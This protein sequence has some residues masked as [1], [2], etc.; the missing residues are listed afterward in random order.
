[1]WII[2]L[3]H[4][5]SMGD[6]FSASIN[7]TSRLL[8][9]A[10][11]D[12]KLA[13][14]KEV[15]IEEI[16]ELGADVKLALFGFTSMTHLVFEG[17]A[18]QKAA[19]ESSLEAL[20]ATN[21][22]SID[23][24]LNA[25]AD[26]RASHRID[27]LARV[28]LIS[29]GLSDRNAAKS[30]ARR[31]LELSMSIHFILIDPTEEG[32]AFARDV[33][34]SLGG[35][36]FSVTSRAQLK[37]STED[38][39]NA[40][41]EDL[42]I[43]ESFNKLAIDQSEA[44]RAEA[45]TRDP[46]EFTTGYPSRIRSNHTYPLLVWVYREELKEKVEQRLGKLAKMLGE[47]PKSSQMESNTLIPIGTRLEITPRIAGVSVNPSR[48]QLTWF[49]EIE[50]AV[51]RIQYDESQG[52]TDFCVGFIDVSASGLLIAKIP[53][54]ISFSQTKAQLLWERSNAQMISRVF[55]SYAR[56]DLAV[57]G[58]KAAYK[59]LGI[60]LFIDKY[61]ISSG[62]P[63]QDVIRRSIGDHDLFQLFW[64]QYAADSDNVSKEWHLALSIAAQRS[65]DFVRPLYWSEPMA[66]PPKD[67]A[68]I[69]FTFL[70]LRNLNID[71]K[72]TENIET[73]LLNEV[74]ADFPI[75]NVVGYGNQA[76]T[77]L[78]HDMCKIVPFLEQIVQGRYYP[79]VSF[80]VDEHIVR[81]T[82]Q[83]W[84]SLYHNEQDGIQDN[85]MIDHVLDLLQSLA[86]AFHVG[87]LV[88]KD[89]YE[90]EKRE[91]FFDVL[92]DCAKEEYW[93]VVRMSEGVFFGPVRQY[94]GGHDVL[95]DSVQS[96]QSLLEAVIKGDQNGF[97]IKS[98]LQWLLE[99]ASDKDSYI[100][101]ETVT[102]NLLEDLSSF[103]TARIKKAAC[104]LSNSAIPQLAAKYQ[105][106]L[107]FGCPDHTELRLCR[108]FPEYISKLCAQW[109]CYVDTALMKRGDITIE[110]GFSVPNAALEWM[111]KNLL[112]IQIRREEEASGYMI[113]RGPEVYFDL[114]LSDYR[115]CVQKLSEV[116]LKILNQ[117]GNYVGLDIIPVAA[118]TYG[119]Y[120]PASAE[121]AQSKFEG[122]LI[123]YGWPKQA[124][125]PGQGKI[126][127]CAEATEKIKELL[128]NSG[129]VDARATDLAHRIALAVL[130]HEQFHSA[131]ATAIGPDG[132]PP[133]GTQQWDS[134][135]EGRALNEALATWAERHFFRKDPEMSEYIGAYINSGVYPAWPYSGAN[136]IEEI[137]QNG[138]LPAVRGW[139]QYLRDDPMNAQR[140]FDNKVKRHITV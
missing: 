37:K 134:W 124:G 132:R 63:W 120:I 56:E 19:I 94:F 110:I 8:M 3:D 64:S 90:H 91:V 104:N 46:V 84:S 79:P 97:Y 114:G 76:V 51:F 60:N 9:E 44:V 72:R 129:I 41:Q 42:K 136:F 68:D 88:P 122:T 85:S 45:E 48:L 106:N 71:P 89:M 87:K 59:G 6:P 52:I 127:I 117:R 1:M 70:D 137:Y 49:G 69:N 23:V 28:V 50:E 98:L 25:A 82:Q 16:G 138:G 99:V 126:L 18:V 111:K 67:L 35:T 77:A 75:M 118:S 113:K 130:I 65:E 131:V 43:A 83:M 40:Y 125:I 123:K 105:V 93:H 26:Y 39:R 14:A 30:A 32:K 108:T 78:C 10:T 55:A 140:E 36:S 101:R 116:L 34:G 5:G 24:A 12:I 112:D 107:V 61:D 58:C 109:L 100:I 13:A 31:C 115:I 54:S 81:T 121:L 102:D 29:D 17:T 15:L 96:M 57:N 128:I 73:M 33:V 7:G 103:E 80:I 27:D 139:I 38:S 21:G 74:E 22:T 62:K 135:Q 11:A 119:V 66:D 95:G 47:M 53:V 92:D 4:S 133:L 20:E 2:L 86:L